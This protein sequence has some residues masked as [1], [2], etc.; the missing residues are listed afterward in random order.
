MVGVN[1]GT[2]TRGMILDFAAGGLETGALTG[3][4]GLAGVIFAGGVV[5]IVGIVL[6][7]VAFAGG[8]TVIPGE[9]IPMTRLV[10]HNAAMMP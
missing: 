9:P 10:A 6:T 4:T 8:V 3:V 1:G 5:L 2:T 7:G